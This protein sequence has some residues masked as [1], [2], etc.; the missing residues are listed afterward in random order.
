VNRRSAWIL[1]SVLIA[2]L[3]PVASIGSQAVPGRQVT[4]FGIRATAGGGKIDDKLKKIEPQLRKLFPGQN[5]SFELIATESKRLAI[6]QLVT[7]DFGAGFVA[8]AELVSIADI[9]GNIQM[10]FALEY[11]KKVE[12]ATLVRTPPNQLF[13]CDKALPDGSKLLIGLG[14][15]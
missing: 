10:R 4:L 7:C 2:G 15:R 3:G 6:G 14:G 9:D 11:E 12:F 5:Y 13:F 8:G 1:A